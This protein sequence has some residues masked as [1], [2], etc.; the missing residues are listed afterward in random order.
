MPTCDQYTL[1]AAHTTCYAAV[2]SAAMKLQRRILTELAT[3]MIG[4]FLL[5]YKL[6]SHHIYHL[7]TQTFVCDRIWENNPYGTKF[8]NV[9]FYV[10]LKLQVCSLFCSLF[11]AH[12]AFRCVVMGAN[13]R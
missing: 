12:R 6:R 13:T 2:L 1:L 4:Y 11:Q 9:Y 5:K 10:G 7:S 3:D 8:K